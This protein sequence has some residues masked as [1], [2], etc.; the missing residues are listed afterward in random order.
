MWHRFPPTA[1]WVLIIPAW[2]LTLSVIRTWTGKKLSAI[3][4][5]YI[6]LPL[7]LAVFFFAPG[8]IGPPL[9]F[10]IPVCCVIGTCAGVR[11]HWKTPLARTLTILTVLTSVCLATFGARDYHNYDQMPA[12]EKEQFLPVWEAM[13][14]R[15]Q[16]TG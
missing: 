6:A 13:E 12:V 11:K 3:P 4:G 2:F 16:N 10:W 5:I 14:K 8:M 1:S 15:E 9:G 7:V